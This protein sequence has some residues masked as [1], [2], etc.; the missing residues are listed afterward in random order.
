MSGTVV[1]RLLLVKGDPTMNTDVRV[2]DKHNWVSILLIV[3][4]VAGL[5]TTLL[6][7]ALIQ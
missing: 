1:A 5:L 4:A 7:P 6:L 2:S 3:L